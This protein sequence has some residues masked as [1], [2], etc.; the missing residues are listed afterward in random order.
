MVQKDLLQRMYNVL[1]VEQLHLLQMILLT[2]E[3][4][5]LRKQQTQ[6]TRGYAAGFL[7]LWYIAPMKDMQQL[8]T[9]FHFLEGLK[10]LERY[11]DNVFWRD[12]D[13]KRWESVADHT[14][15][16]GM[17]LIFVEKRLTQTI[18][19]ARALKLV[20][21]HDLPE[22][23][24]GDPSP[25]GSD[26]TGKD[27]HRFNP[28]KRRE[29]EAREAA[30]AEEI[31]AMLPTEDGEEFYALWKEYEEQ[32]TYESQVVKAIDKVEARLQTIEMSDCCVYK[33]HLE[34]MVSMNV[35]F[36]KEPYLKEINDELVKHI[37][38]NYTE[39]TK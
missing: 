13:I 21:I 14:W 11:K 30:A 4:R 8:I 34:P 27:S 29:K 28:E 24:A 16:M 31:I 19:L 33:D 37:K 1:T 35:E 22:I 12:Y 7:C 32:K 39:F 26:G 38:E 3:L 2:K 15:R 9:F 20:L 17:I 25:L 5:K 6:K 36:I 10:K 23:I 18:D